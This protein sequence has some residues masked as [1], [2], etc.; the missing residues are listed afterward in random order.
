[1]TAIEEAQDL[2][3]I[4]LNDLMGNLMAYEVHMQERREEEKPT[5]KN[6]AFPAMSEN[7]SD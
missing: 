5:K 3:K 1:M 2:S 6:I 4:T 7:D